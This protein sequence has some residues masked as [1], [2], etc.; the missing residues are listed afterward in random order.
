MIRSLLYR[1]LYSRSMG[2]RVEK[3]L[4]NLAYRL[5]S[6]AGHDRLRILRYLACL[7]AVNRCY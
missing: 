4:L 1:I 3:D 5:L 7:Q 6:I 2:M